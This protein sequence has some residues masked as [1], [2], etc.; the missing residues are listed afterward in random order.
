MES[1]PNIAFPEIRSIV[2]TFCADAV[3]PDGFERLYIWPRTSALHLRSLHQRLKFYALTFAS[4]QLRTEFQPIYMFATP[5]WLSYPHAFK[6]LSDFHGTAT[7]ISGNIT[8]DLY[9]L[10][11]KTTSKDEDLL[12]FLRKLATYRGLR[13]RFRTFTT[14]RKGRSLFGLGALLNSCLEKM[15]TPEW[16]RLVSAQGGD[17]TKIV[18][19]KSTKK[20]G[21]Y[22]RPGNASWRRFESEV[23]R[24]MGLDG[25]SSWTA[26]VKYERRAY[27]ELPWNAFKIV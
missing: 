3:S 27:E 8:I 14:A 25:R 10:C 4:R 15:H 5:A 17:V 20:L 1:P 23:L 26:I 16:Q 7:A 2:Y 6:C 13:V 9:D 22:V 21:V 12:P 11:L 24:D 18:L 19:R